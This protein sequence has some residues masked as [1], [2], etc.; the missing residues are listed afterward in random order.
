MSSDPDPSIEELIRQL[1]ETRIEET[2]IIGQLRETR[3]EETRIIEQIER[4]RFRERLA[5]TTGHIRAPANT[6]GDAPSNFHTGDRVRITNGVK[7]GQVPTG[8]VTKVGPSR[9]SILTDN[10]V[11]IQRARKNVTKE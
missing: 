10:G 11:T 7:A 4:T 3:I 1:K 5:R 2:R 9:I 8:K 6:S